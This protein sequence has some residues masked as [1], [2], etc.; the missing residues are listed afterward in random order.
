MADLPKTVVVSLDDRTMDL[1]LDEL[2]V[3]AGHPP[4]TDALGLARWDLKAALREY[5]LREQADG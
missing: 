5:A 4:H 2:T 1:I 3:R